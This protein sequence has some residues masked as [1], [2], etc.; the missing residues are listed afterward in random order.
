MP[1]LGAFRARDASQ[2]LHERL[3]DCTLYIDGAEEMMSSD[4]ERIPKPHDYSA[5]ER[6]F[7]DSVDD[8][9]YN[10]QYPMMLLSGTAS[11]LG[12]AVYERKSY[13]L[14]RSKMRPRFLE[15]KYTDIEMLLMMTRQLD[16][17]NKS[18]D[19]KWVP[20]LASSD[21]EPSLASVTA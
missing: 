6:V 2:W 17:R 19:S 20:T 10:P 7:W 1:A 9:V 13:S 4:S 5:K 14:Q 3:I 8:I 16:A 21:D 15:H 11:H 18:F 12:D